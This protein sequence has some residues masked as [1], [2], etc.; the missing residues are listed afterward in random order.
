M[1]LL[2]YIGI[3]AESAIALSLLVLISDYI[4]SSFGFGMWYRNPIKI[5]ENLNNVNTV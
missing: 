2:G 5:R 1:I 4:L 3:A